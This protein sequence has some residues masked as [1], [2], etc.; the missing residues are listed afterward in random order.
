ME[1]LILQKNKHY[2]SLVIDLSLTFEQY[3]ALE[4]HSG[5]NVKEECHL[6]IPTSNMKIGTFSWDILIFNEA[7]LY[8]QEDMLNYE[9][10]ITIKSQLEISITILNKS[11]IT[12][13]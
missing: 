1:L 9:I 3:R 4:M 6:S 2:P 7:F 13:S 11:H 10:N 12:Q 5:V 8:F